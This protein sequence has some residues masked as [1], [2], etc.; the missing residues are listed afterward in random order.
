VRIDQ[1]YLKRLL[2]AFEDS[3]DPCTTIKIL[4]GQGFAIDDEFM[5]H[6]RILADKGFVEREDGDAGIGMSRGLSGGVHWF[7]VPLRLTAKGHEFIETIRNPDV[8]RKTKDGMAKVENWGL[9]LMFAVAKA[10][11][12]QL[13]REKLGLDL[14]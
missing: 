1:E 4:E 12:K 9:D 3:P 13:A 11:G 2:L 10:Y 8:W 14:G 7:A 6:M 5:F